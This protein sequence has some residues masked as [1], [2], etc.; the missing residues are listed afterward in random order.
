M[1]QSWVAINLAQDHKWPIPMASLLWVSSI[2][3]NLSPVAHNISYGQASKED[4]FEDVLYTE[5][6]LM[7]QPSHIHESS[8]VVHLF[9]CSH[10][11]KEMKWQED[12]HDGTRTWWHDVKKTWWQGASQM[13]HLKAHCHDVPLL[14]LAAVEDLDLRRVIQ[15]WHG[16][17]LF[18]PKMWKC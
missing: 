11:E 12:R 16:C 13:I 4:R 3:Q 2:Y 1:V 18:I 14:V 8:N 9:D 10:V 7:Q 5:Y 15:F 6:A 17:T